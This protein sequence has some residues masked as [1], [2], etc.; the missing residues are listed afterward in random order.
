MNT[1]TCV[2][3]SE[4]LHCALAPAWEWVVHENYTTWYDGLISSSGA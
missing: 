1:I 3:C 2:N 4:E